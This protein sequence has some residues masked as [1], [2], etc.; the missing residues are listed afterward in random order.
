MFWLVVGSSCCEVVNLSATQLLLSIAV[1]TRQEPDI[2]PLTLRRNSYANLITRTK[3]NPDPNINRNKPNRNL[4]SV[5][6][7][8]Q[9]IENQVSKWSL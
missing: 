6:I 1:P 2:I 9:S 4:A 8:G 3:R 7:S 5:K